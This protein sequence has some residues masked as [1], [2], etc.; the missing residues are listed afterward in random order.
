MLNPES[1]QCR[2]PAKAIRVWTTSLAVGG[3][4]AAAPSLSLAQTSVTVYGIMDGGVVYQKDP[5]GGGPSK[6]SITGGGYS[7]SRLGFRGQE[8][9]GG[10]NKAFFN[11]ETGINIDDGTNTLGVFWGRLS[12]IGVSGSFG[13]LTAGRQLTPFYKMVALPSDAFSV[14]LMGCNCAL[15]NTSARFNN[16]V[17]YTTPTWSGLKASGFYSLSEG[18][19]G[20]HLSTAVS[21]TTGPVYL[22][23]GYYD[24][25][26]FGTT[27]SS[28]G[29]MFAAIY[30]PGPVKL[31]GSFEAIR[32]SANGVPGVTKVNTNY[33]VYRVSAQIPSG[34]HTLLLGLGYADDQRRVGN[35]GASSV[36]SAVGYT[37]G[38]SKQTTFYT[39]LGKLNNKKGAAF[40]VLDGTT[41][42]Y[43]TLGFDIGL[44][45]NF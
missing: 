40:S 29:S 15:V 2:R 12:F 30:N 5:V 4:V 10:G 25:E 21:Y 31:L 41:P 44:R 38:L 22:S 24:T 9:L 23:A 16:S 27:P 6:T 1:K 28:R 42:A 8:D 45:V 26:R 36:H 35:T 13:E 3:L 39:S 33:D 14:G 32:S 11:I 19:T 7:G 17:S 37:Y 20:R 18:S 34:R 43:G